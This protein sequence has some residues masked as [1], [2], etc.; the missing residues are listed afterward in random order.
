VGGKHEGLWPNAINTRLQPCVRDASEASKQN[1]G[2]KYSNCSLTNRNSR[3]LVLACPPISVGI[4]SHGSYIAAY[5]IAFK[6]SS[7]WP[8][9]KVRTNATAAEI[10]V[11]GLNLD[12]KSSQCLSFVRS[13]IDNRSNSNLPFRSNLWYRRT[14]LC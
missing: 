10:L 3:R 2:Q 7:S 13:N 5:A 8:G 4:S 12:R 6:H 11:W 1:E 14:S 9:F